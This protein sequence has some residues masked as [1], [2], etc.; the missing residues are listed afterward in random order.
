MAKARKVESGTIAGPAEAEPKLGDRLT[1]TVSW[2]GFSPQEAP[3][4]YAEAFQD[5]ELV[6]GAMQAVHE[7]DVVFQKFGYDSV[8][9]NTLG[10]AECKVSLV[11]YAGLS[12][13]GT[14][15]T[16]ASVEFHADG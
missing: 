15:A 12:K 5:G 2:D 13:G 11:A 1:F 7:A 16:V 8:W 9:S 4:V 10:P 14:R 6:Y 3:Y